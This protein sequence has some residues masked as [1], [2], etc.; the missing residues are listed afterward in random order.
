[1]FEIMGSYAFIGPLRDTDA[2]GENAIFRGKVEVA[3]K[4]VRCYIKPFPMSIHGQGGAIVE[5]REVISEALGYALAKVCGLNVAS[6]AGVI[7]LELDQIPEA[8][9]AKLLKQSPKGA[10][11]AEYL[12]WFSEDMRHPALA[13]GCPSDAAE[14]LLLKNFARIA[15]ELADHK[16][17]PAIVSF[18]E[19][20]EN[21]DRHFGNL[22]GCPSGTL[23]LIDHGRLFRHPSWDPKT[24]STNPLE[25]HNALKVLIDS[26]VPGWSDRTPIRSARALAYNGFS[27]AWQA[28]GRE[29]AENVLTEFLEEPEVT[30]VLDF[31]ASRLEPQQYNPRVGLMV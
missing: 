22:L 21:N 11:Q 1:M 24:L 2:S 13:I 3:G 29:S 14:L 6:T 8:A 25:P 27:V 10:S 30:L 16:S 23:T 20:T 31:L 18:D 28:D 5:N 15:A 26:Q 17:T 4:T 7:I 12:A 19:W 9:R